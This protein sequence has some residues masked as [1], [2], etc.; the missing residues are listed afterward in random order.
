MSAAQPIPLPLEP[1]S[2]PP[3]PQSVEDTGVDFSLL[4]E[5]VA[6][7][8]YTRGQLRLPDLS[9][10][11][12]LPVGVVTGLIVFMRSERLCEMARQGP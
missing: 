10:H 5:L 11:V 12:Q 4:V 7:V 6:K 1:S 8:L 2:L 3:P 9:A